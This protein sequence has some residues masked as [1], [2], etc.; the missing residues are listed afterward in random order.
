MDT[1]NEAQV[2]ELIASWTH[3]VRSK[4]RD[5]LL[6]CHTDDVVLFDVIPPLQ[7]QGL[8]A[9]RQQWELFFA[10]DPGG[11]GSFELTDLHVSTGDTIAFAHALLKVAGSTARLT[12]GCRKLDGK[13][14]IAHEHHSF[15]SK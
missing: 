11:P 5:A 15:S 13:W 2:R 7:I 1:S 9:Y 10:V 3:A 4:D 8:E 14:L 6:A 12:L